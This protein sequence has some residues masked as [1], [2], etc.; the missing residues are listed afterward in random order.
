MEVLTSSV[1]VMPFQTASTPLE[2]SS[3]ILLSQLISM[4]SAF[5]PKLSAKAFA[6]SASKPTHSSE[7]SSL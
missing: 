4:N 2:S 5:T 3:M 6:M 1:R 7:P